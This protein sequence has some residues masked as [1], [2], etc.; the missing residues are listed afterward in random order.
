MSGKGRVVA[1]CRLEHTLIQ[2]EE[3]NRGLSLESQFG[4]SF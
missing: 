2:G 3:G 4:K 1:K